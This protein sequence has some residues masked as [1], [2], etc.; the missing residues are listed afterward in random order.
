VAA[1]V[2]LPAADQLAILD[3]II[4]ADEAAS[5]RDAGAYVALFTPDAVLD[6][7]Q[8]QYAGRQAL[9]ASVGPIWA[10]EGPATLHHPQPG[11]RARPPRRPR[12]RP[13]RTAD[14]RPPRAARH[15]RR[16]ADHQGTPPVR[17]RLGAS[18]GAPSPRPRAVTDR[19]AG[20]ADRRRRMSRQEPLQLRDAERQANVRRG[21]RHPYPPR[22]IHDQAP[23]GA[24]KFLPGQASIQA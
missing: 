11:H 3:V 6:R 14:H 5:R 23:D 2:T 12:G 19:A 4:R 1:A 20:Q 16:C 8:G 17:R 13:V 22:A 24:C 21:A 10:A 15:P 7:A 18:P 9:R